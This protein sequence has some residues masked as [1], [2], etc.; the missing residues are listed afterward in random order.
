MSL[1]PE[2]I[3]STGYNSEAEVKRDV[4]KFLMNYYNRERPHQFNYDI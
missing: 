4:S 3:P 1:K 2:W